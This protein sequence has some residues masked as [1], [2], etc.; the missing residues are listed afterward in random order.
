MAEQKKEK[1]G[2]RGLLWAGF[3]L[4]VLLA[5][6][7]PLILIIS[8]TRDIDLVDLLH[9]SPRQEVE[10]APE[11]PEREPYLAQ[12]LYRFCEHHAVYEPDSIPTDLEL[13]PAA[14]VEMAVALH[15]SN[16]SIQDIMSHLKDTAGWHV[17]D[18]RTGPDSSFFTFTYLDDL[19]PECRGRYY[20]GI[21][22]DG[23]D[24]YIALYEGRA[25]GGKL[26]RVTPYRVRDDIREELEEGVALESPEEL[27]EALQEYTS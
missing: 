20:L 15:D 10:T 7:G 12:Y 13:P 3:V 5:G 4:L 1:K 25:P 11:T 17:A 9:R 18:V 27:Q 14:L 19:C 22:S 26:I 8:Y 23:A 2:A 6:L 21:F 16:T 24:D